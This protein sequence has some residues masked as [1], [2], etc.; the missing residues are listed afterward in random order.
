MTY[1]NVCSFIFREL[2]ESRALENGQL[3]LGIITSGSSIIP[4]VGRGR[5]TMPQ[6][7]CHR[8]EIYTLKYHASKVSLI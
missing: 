2:K 8:V 1:P 6:E 4:K 7:L 5:G 3:K